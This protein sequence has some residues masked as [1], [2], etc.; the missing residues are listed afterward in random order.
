MTCWCIS[1]FQIFIQRCAQCHTVEAGGKH[2]VGPNLHGLV[3]RKTGQSAGFLYTDA[4]K[5]K[6]MYLSTDIIKNDKFMNNIKLH[7]SVLSIVLLV[8]RINM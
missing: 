1:F 3:G 8:L 6:G 5:A 2:K 4:N 7:Y